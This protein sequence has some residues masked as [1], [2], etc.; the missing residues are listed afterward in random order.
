VKGIPAQDAPADGQSGPRTSNATRK[1][2]ATV[3]KRTE[4]STTTPL[5]GCAGGCASSKTRRRRGGIYPLSHLYG[6]FGLVRLTALGHD[7]VWVKA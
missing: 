4:R 1:F 5:C 6:R 7:V 3:T 2:H